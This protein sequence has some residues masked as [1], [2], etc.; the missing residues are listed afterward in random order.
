MIT[1]A[2]LV[3]KSVQT[4]AKTQARDGADA[5]EEDKAAR[6]HRPIDLVVAIASVTIAVFAAADLLY[7]PSPPSPTLSLSLSLSFSLS[8][9]L[10]LSLSSATSFL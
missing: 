5:A 7:S 3:D 9:T 4:A 10:S 2:A 8:L 1:A 6:I